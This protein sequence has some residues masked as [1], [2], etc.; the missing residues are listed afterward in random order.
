[1]PQ[2]A[3]SGGLEKLHFGQMLSSLAA[4]LPQKI[5]PSGLSNWHFGHFICGPESGYGGKE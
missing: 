4:H 3:K 1:L 2:K 5:I